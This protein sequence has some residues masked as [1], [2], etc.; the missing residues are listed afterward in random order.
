MEYKSTCHA[1]WFT[2]TRHTRSPQLL[3]NATVDVEPLEE[4]SNVPDVNE[5]SICEIIAPLSSY[6]T[7]IEECC[8][9]ITD[10]LPEVKAGV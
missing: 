8:K 3:D 7:S 10:I 1:A 9:F 6:T 5:R 4:W 2:T